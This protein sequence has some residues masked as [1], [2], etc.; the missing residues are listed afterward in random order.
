MA[1]ARDRATH[2]RGREDLAGVVRL[3][4]RVERHRDRARFE[5]R[6]VREPPLGAVFALDRDRRAGADA[7]GGE[8]R[9]ER[10]HAGRAFTKRPARPLRA[11]EARDEREVAVLIGRAMDEVGN[12]RD[13]RAG[14][15]LGEALAHRGAPGAGA[16]ASSSAFASE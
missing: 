9:G 8:S 7:R 4:L 14:R 10:A 11:V 13:R 3:Q 12:A 15:G 2:T 1:A 16:R 5:D 6:K